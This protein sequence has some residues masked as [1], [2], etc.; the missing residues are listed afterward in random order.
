MIY[1]PLAER[2]PRARGSPLLVQVE[3]AAELAAGDELLPKAPERFRG[4][5]GAGAT[6]LGRLRRRQRS[7]SGALTIAAGL[8]GGRR[9]T[10]LLT[11]TLF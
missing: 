5:H 11:L 1:P 4:T 7:W 8:V 10:G 3:G 9:V 2:K 6:G